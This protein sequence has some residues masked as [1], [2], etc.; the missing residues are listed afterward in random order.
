MRKAIF[1]D[2]DGTLTDGEPTWRS[3]MV[4]ALGPLADQYGI[5]EE[6]L[7]GH[8]QHGFPWHKDGDPTLTGEAFWNV[9]LARFAEAYR[10]LGIPSEL[11]EQAAHRVRKVVL[12]KNLYHVRPDAAAT[13]ALCAYNGWRNYILSN[14]YPELEQ[15]IDALGLRQFFSGL[16]VSG[17]VGACKPD[18]KIFRLAERAA[19]FPSL[20]WMVGDNPVADI[21]GARD[22]GWHTAYIAPRGATNA[23]AEVTVTGLSELLKYL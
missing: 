9:L 13:L 21:K 15:T 18:E 6:M 10:A 7:R 19:N 16:V 14:N 2:F 22:A 12:D 5:T 8:L 3:C 11:A 4:R 17:V 23:G 1:W 20:I